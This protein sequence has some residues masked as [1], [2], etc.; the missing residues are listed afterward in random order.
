MTTQSTDT[1]LEITTADQLR[2]LIGEPKGRAVSKERTRLL[3]IDH[4]WLAASPYCVLATSDEN[5]L[6]D[7]SPKG[8]PPGFVRVLDDA[9]IAIPERP[10]NR[11]ADGYLNILRNPHVG[12]LSIIPGRPET[13]RINGRAKLVRDAPYFEDMV[14]RG[15]RPILA[16][17][18]AI[19]QIFFHCPKS[20]LRSDLW[21]PE[22]WHPEVL[23]PHAVIV[24]SVQQTEETLEELMEYYGPQYR[25]GLY[26]APKA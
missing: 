10:G 16:I 25:N 20:A 6:C 13:L 17:E 5:G 1:D 19:E 14:V 24:K 3:P 8:D 22:S 11:R 7:A 4:Q 23:P 18:V 21:Q 26:A 9:T 15:H 2:E 12:L